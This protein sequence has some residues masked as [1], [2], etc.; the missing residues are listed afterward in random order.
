M[1]SHDIILIPQGWCLAC[2]QQY[3]AIQILRLTL[4][5][6]QIRLQEH[7]QSLS[8]EL[9]LQVSRILV[10]FSWPRSQ[11]R[12]DQSFRHLS[13][14][15]WCPLQLHWAAQGG[16]PNAFLA[17]ILFSLLPQPWLKQY[18]I[19]EDAWVILKNVWHGEVMYPYLVIKK[20][21]NSIAEEITYRPTC[22]SQKKRSSTKY[23][24][25]EKHSLSKRGSQEIPAK[26]FSLQLA[27]RAIKDWLRRSSDSDLIRNSST[28]FIS[29]K[30]QL[31]R[32]ISS[33][34]EDVP[35]NRSS[36]D[37]HV[38]HVAPHENVW[39]DRSLN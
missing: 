30:Q 22:E 3:L 27:T 29:I 35:S 31:Q 6:L 24:S 28:S 23:R 32:I 36:S 39:P 4:L 38:E 13:S 8:V 20:A 18:M 10:S 11:G 34:A 14:C 15:S 12:V 16:D 1:I 5:P 37:E 25:Q 33:K 26:D 2:S 7:H 21:M 9:L 19:V 17:R